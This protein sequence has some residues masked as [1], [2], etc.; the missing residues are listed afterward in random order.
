MRGFGAVPKR[1]AEVGG[2]LLGTIEHGDQTIVRIEDFEP[3]DCGYKRGPSYLLVE[4]DGMAFADACTRWERD[5]SKAA[6]VV[7]FYRSNTREGF[8]CAP[9]DVELMNHYF[10]E[11]SET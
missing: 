1:A 3:V 10:P 2:L 6:Y 7:G 11:A 8:T 4:E 9:V 5:S